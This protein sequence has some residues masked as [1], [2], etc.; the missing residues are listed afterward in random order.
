MSTTI[1]ELSPK[2]EALLV[3]VNQID[4]NLKLIDVLNHVYSSHESNLLEKARHDISGDDL[5][6]FQRDFDM[7][8]PLITDIYFEVYQF[9]ISEAASNDI[10]D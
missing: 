4:Q 9:V 8:I 2:Y 7:L 6:K 3:Y 5:S 10:D 1:K